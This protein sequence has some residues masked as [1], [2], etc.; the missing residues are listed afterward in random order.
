VWWDVTLRSGEAYDEVTEAALRGAK[1]VVVLWS[2]RSVN[3]RWVRAEATIADRNKTL[4]PATIEPCDLP[5]MFELTQTADLS[6]W[7]GGTDDEVWLAFLDD[8][9]RKV[10]RGGP[11][12]EAPPSVRTT[13]SAGAGV[14]Q[15]GVLPF[16]VRGDDGELGFLAEDLTEDVTRALAEDDYFKV[17]VAGKM[18]V[19]RG[20]NPDYGAIGRQL[21]VRY[22]AEGKLQRS[23][24]TIRLTMQLID[25]ATAS[26]DWSHRFAA[27]PAE[28][29][30]N[31]D[32]LPAIVASELAEHMLQAETKRAMSSQGPYSAWEHV[33]R[34]RTVRFH[35]TDGLRRGLEEARSAVAAAP[36]FGLAHAELGASIR[37]S[38][39]F[40]ELV[41]NEATQHEIQQHLT[42][43]LQLD[44]DNA[45]VIS[46]V[47]NIYSGLGDGDSSLRL[48]RR[49]V[50][51]RPNMALGHH[52]L[53]GAYFVLGRTG[54]A[55]GAYANSLH[56]KGYND[57]R[58]NAYY[59]SGWCYLLEGK[60]QDADDA[61][62]QSL[63]L[64]P[65]SF[66]ALKFKAISEA[67]LG[68]E[69]QALATTR[70]LREVAPDMS[71][72]QHIFLIKM[73]P[74]IGRRSDEHIAVLRRLWAATESAG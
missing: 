32:D 52:A 54:E 39:N 8:V 36:D 24:E 9:R 74:R 50:E 42:R 43:A 10:G 6:H 41:Q 67:L 37:L 26:A 12:P 70:R 58:A 1:A 46:I 21:D 30:A 4:M 56:C 73:N 65:H 60:P 22:L 48:A 49:A 7:R 17:I 11:E 28:L 5:I 34:S 55:I 29:A 63:R 25:T 57:L 69:K 72:D 13:A 68:K 40:R 61:L 47:G 44:G 53:A 51:L 23:G 71:L 2:P 15:A 31:P 38:T 59:L 18:A 16:T 33:L 14:P 27:S 19:W 3:S 62:D 35:G 64:N 20:K 66:L 45:T